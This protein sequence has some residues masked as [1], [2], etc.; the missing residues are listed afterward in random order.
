VIERVTSSDARTNQ[1]WH[2]ELLIGDWYACFRGAPGDTSL[3][4]HLAHQIVVVPTGHVRAKIEAEIIERS[5]IFIPALVTHQLIECN[6]PA[7]V[8]FVEPYAVPIERLASFTTLS[9]S[10][11][12]DDIAKALQS[13][14][15]ESIVG[16]RVTRLVSAIDDALAQSSNVQDIAQRLAVSSSQLQ[17]RTHAALG[18]P[19]RRLVRWRRLRRALIALSS[20]GNLTSAAHEAG[21]S[22][23]AHFSRTM[24]D[25]FGVRADRALLGATLSVDSYGVV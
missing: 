24:R 9:L 25:M 19:V 2:G 7:W 11:S 23:S 16:E 13:M 6:E 22:D 18:V 4:Q 1:V 20:G 3:H 10:N 15:V 14:R 5:T 21:F 12:P 17:R 8:I